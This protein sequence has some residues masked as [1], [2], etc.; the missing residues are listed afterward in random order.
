M[1]DRFAEF[2]RVLDSESWEWLQ[3]N[4]PTVAS[5]IERMVG[6]GV[7]P[8]EIRRRVLERSGAHRF[9]FAQRCESA[10]RWLTSEKA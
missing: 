6:R 9:A 8:E 1:S 5:T 10:A 3:D 7:A 4:A 2:D